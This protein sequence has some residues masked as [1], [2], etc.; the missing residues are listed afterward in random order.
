MLTRLNYCRI[1]FLVLAVLILAGNTFAAPT[2]KLVYS[3]PG[4]AHGVHPDGGLIAD[5]D[6]NLYGTTTLGGAD[7]HGAVF[8][9]SPPAA[10]GGAWTE[11]VLYSFQGS[12]LDGALPFGT[13]IFDK[14]GNLYGTTY[15]GGNNDRGSIFELSP[16]VAPGGV[17]T[18][19]VLWLFGA[20]G[21]AGSVAHGQAGHRPE[22][23]SL[24]NHLWPFKPRRLPLRAGLRAGKAEG[25]GG[26]GG[27]DSLQIW[28]DGRRW[29]LSRA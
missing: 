15:S 20:N 1:A 16:P 29:S 12:P 3:F 21:R 27:T 22:W 13:L 28:R 18:E 10:P 24:R 5:A 8:E 11:T 19:T 26:M 6:G 25:G 23:Q 17:W 2:E 4:P 7:K 9:L 14:Q